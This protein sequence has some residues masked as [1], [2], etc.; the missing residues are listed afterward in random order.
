MAMIRTALLV[1]G[2]HARA[3]PWRESPQLP[4]APAGAAEAESV[5]LSPT[6]GRP[7]AMNSG[8]GASGALDDASSLFGWR[9]SREEE[10]EEL[11]LQFDRPNANAIP[12][13][14]AVPPASTRT[15]RFAVDDDAPDAYADFLGDAEEKKGER[16]MHGVL[17]ASV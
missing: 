12:A 6:P 3:R 11:E 14:A 15:V 10:D 17:H 16:R 8:S 7:I 13:A 9:R 5:A 1:S 4:D 2:R